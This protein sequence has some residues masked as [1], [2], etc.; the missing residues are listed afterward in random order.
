MK[1][2]PVVAD[3][4]QN[5]YDSL[6]SQYDKFYRDWR[7]TTRA[8]AVFLDGI[9]REY[10]FDR[11]ARLLDCACGIGTQAIGLAALGYAV[12]ASD[13]SAG[14]LAEAQKRAAESQVTLTLKQADFRALAE[15]FPEPFDLV[16]AMD[17][18]L[19]HMLSH[20]SLEE[21]VNSIVNQLRGGGL[22]VASIRDYDKALEEK[23]AFS[24]PYVHK[25]ERGQR[26]LFQTWDWFGDNYQ[27]TQY[28]IEDEGT[29]EISKF[30]CEYRATRRDEL[31]GLLL[32]AGCT[33]VHWKMP[34]ETGFYQPVVVAVK[35]RGEE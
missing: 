24:A 28:I 21:A 5:F 33:A 26:I 15:V 1:N 32:A 2:Q 11:T 27:F 25:T 4:T 3:V 17:N 35:G 20:A 19:P 29:P 23:P 7:E 22:F 8:E 10:G 13:I 9:F 12:T 14:E 16:I 31:T 6:A 30:C 18:A 34:K